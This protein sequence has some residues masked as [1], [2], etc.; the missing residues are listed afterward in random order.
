[1]QDEEIILLDVSQKEIG[2]ET[3]IFDDRDK[4][5]MGKYLGDVFCEVSIS[6]AT[7][8]DA[9]LPVQD[10]SRAL[11]KHAVGTYIVWWKDYVYI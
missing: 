1:M 4:M 9:P 2:K 3:F 6:H 7:K 11:M 5:L 10:K 8:P